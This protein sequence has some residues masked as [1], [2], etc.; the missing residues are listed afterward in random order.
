[1][2]AL[3]YFLTFLSI[4]FAGLESSASCNYRDNTGPVN[5]PLMV[6][7][8][9]GDKAAVGRLLS[10]KST[11]N[12]Q[13][14]LCNDGGKALH[15]TPLINAV[16]ATDSRVV[17]DHVGMVEF[18]LL[19][20]AS[21]DFSADGF[22]PLHMAAC[23]GNLPVVKMLLRFGASVDPHADGDTPLLMAVQD[24]HIE[25]VQELIAAGADLNVHDSLGGNLVSI[26]AS[27]H[28]QDIV[29][30]L[31]KLGVD[32][33]AKDNDGNDAIYWADFGGD[34]RSEREAIIGFLKSKCGRYD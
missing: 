10:E 21:P 30:L 13:F 22:T 27:Q 20:G 7:I 31:V 33:C 1:M 5:T 3:K 9:Q 18:L 16:L 6:S 26:A 8:W 25:V 23:V 12:L 17:A 14:S 32:P 29:R 28:Y 19:H 24:G 11:L 2:R 15:T 4:F 34:K